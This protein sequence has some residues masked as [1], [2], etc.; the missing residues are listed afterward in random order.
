MKIVRLIAATA[1]AIGALA[2]LVLLGSI[3]E[4]PEHEVA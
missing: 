3:A 4:G 1:G 2:L